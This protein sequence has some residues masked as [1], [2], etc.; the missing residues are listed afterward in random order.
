MRKIALRGLL[1]QKRETL[2]LWSVVT[3]SFLFLVLSTTIITSLQKTDSDQRIDTYG[4]WQIMTQTDTQAEAQ[5]YADAADS[6]VVQPMIN[7]YGLDYFT[8]GNNYYLTTYSPKLAALGSLKLKEGRWPE[9]A[10][11]V[12]LE[13]AKLSA[14]GLSVGDSFQAAS[15]VYLPEDETAVALR[16]ERMAE[17]RVLAIEKANAPLVQAFRDGSWKKLLVGNPQMMQRSGE[18]FFSWWENGE[19]QNHAMLFADDAHPNGQQLRIAELTEEQLLTALNAY[20]TKYARHLPLEE[21]MTEEEKRYHTGITDLIGCGQRNLRV[22]IKD[23]R[24]MLIIATTYTVCGVTETYSDRWDSGL[25]ELPAGFVTQAHYDELMECQQAAVAAYPDFSAAEYQSLVLARDEGTTG[26]RRLW[27]RAA[28]LYNR[29]RQTPEQLFT[30]FY[31][32]IDADSTEPQSPYQVQF[33]LADPKTEKSYPVTG[34]I[35]A[36]TTPQMQPAFRDTELSVPGGISQ[37]P[38]NHAIQ[39]ELRLIDVLS[40]KYFETDGATVRFEFGSTLQEL[41]L[42]QFFSADFTING[43]N[44]VSAQHLWSSDADRQTDTATLRLNRLAYPSSADG[45]SRM[46]V[47]VTII[48]FVTT[49]CAVFQIFFSQM[50]KRLRR[51]VLMKSIGAQDGQIA[52]MLGWEFLYFLLGALPLGTA[53]GLGGAEAATSALSRVQA[54]TIALYLSPK[55]FAAALCAGT[56]ALALGMLIPIVMAVG[57]PLTGRTVRKKPLPSPKKE[58]RQ[59]FVHITLRSLTA[60]R[61]RALG[62]AALCV[63]MMLTATL[64]LF[65]G[66]RFLT[67][68]RE[69][70]QRDGKPEYLLQSPYSMSD[71]Q[72]QEYL[73]ALEALGVCADV[74]VV[75]MSN[76]AILAD[77]D[78]AGSLLLDTVAQPGEVG[79]ITGQYVTLQG[80]TSQDAMY[81]KYCAAITEGRMDAAAFDA[82]E[83]VLV[84]VPLY[85]ESG[86]VNREALLTAAGWDRL[87]A[88]GIRTSYYAE[89]DGHYRRDTTLQVGDTI[90]L[91]A[92]TRMYGSGGYS[93]N[94]KDRYVRVAAVLYYFPEEGVWPV[95]GSR[96][97]YHIVCSSHLIATMLPNA[98][99]TRTDNEIR[100]IKVGGLIDACGT[101]DFYINGAEDLS[102]EEIDTA[103]LIFARNRYMDIEFYHE[104]NE[105]LLQDAINNILLTCLLGLT[106]TLLALM[107]FANTISSDIEAE[108][109]RIGILQAL[110]VSHRRL[111]GR[112]LCIGLA[113]STLALILANVLLWSGVALYAVLSGTVM[114]NLLWRYPAQLH[115]GICAVMMLII[116]LLYVAPMT[117]LRRY[118]P[119]ENIKSRK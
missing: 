34:W 65:L 66:V 26:A 62:N 78:A 63:F 23:G 71:R 32:E 82:G 2:L 39:R 25:L 61:S 67:P 29:Q 37:F 117:A 74:D 110:G 106:A 119:I 54:R 36:D 22:R 45:S 50:R 115:I 38:G 84:M 73:N 88:A 76:S 79:D 70:V 75:R 72:Q 9:T 97:G 10:N 41:P 48:L 94:I 53:L 5:Q 69:A 11:E 16:E 40:G 49:V 20:W 89:F 28:A 43:L 108:R 96:E 98:I 81:Q 21:L 100:A 8:G 114:G 104:S 35:N 93:Y 19:Y 91:A 57:V 68:W 92:K 42:E 85:R 107:I 7:V 31:N 80:L 55:V 95:S 6:A 14:L 44:P 116:T 111:V 109:S 118:L 33:H 112:Q 103:L 105:K 113:V 12:V 46:L 56:L 87:D 4:S 52:R 64:C 18:L 24:L 27:A 13:Y 86:L 102:R 17:L 47:L 51:I 77:E 3:L 30:V 90:H 101:T 58:V 15:E 60:N 83:E 99:R 1:G 59:D